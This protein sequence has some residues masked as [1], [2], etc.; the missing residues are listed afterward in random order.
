ML[1]GSNVFMRLVS[2]RGQQLQ[3]GDIVREAVRRG[4][5]TSETWNG[6]SERDRDLRLVHTFYDMKE[7]A[8]GR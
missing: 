2:I 8:E 6:L 4:N 1:L 5:F 3:L 7:E